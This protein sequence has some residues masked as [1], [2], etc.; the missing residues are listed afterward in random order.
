[1]VYAALVAWVVSA[2]AGCYLLRPWLAEGG[3]RE[4]STKV[5]RFPIVVVLGH[6][7]FAA[8]GLVAWILH[9]ATTRVVYAWGAFGSLV[10]VTMLGFVMFTRWLVG[11]GGR[12]ARDAAQASPGVAVLVHGLVALVTFVLV[13]FTAIVVSRS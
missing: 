1:V 6:P 7:V 10:V 9:I 11:Q 12:H 2:L 3:L 8:V 4:Q 13:F 5:T